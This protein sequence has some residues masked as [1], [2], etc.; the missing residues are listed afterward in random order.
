[1]D[2]SAAEI[3]ALKALSWAASGEALPRFLGASGIEIDD[4]RDRAGDPELL[5][6]MLDFLLTDDSLVTEFCAAEDISLRDIHDARRALPGAV[7]E[8]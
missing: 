7:L 1:M 5:A 6:A 4:L 3:L 8:P 2:V